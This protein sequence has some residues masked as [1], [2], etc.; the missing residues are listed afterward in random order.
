MILDVFTCNNLTGHYRIRLLM[1]KKKIML[2]NYHADM[3]GGEFAL[4]EH[5]N[6]LL[7]KGMDICV[8]LFHPG[9]LVERL[10]KIGVE[11][12]V[13]NF[14]LKCGPNKAKL[15]GFFLGRHLKKIVTEF[16]PDYILNYTFHEL[17]FFI[18][19]ANCFNIP[20]LYRDQGQAWTNDLNID[21][22]ELKL[23]QWCNSNLQG[24]ICTTQNKF[25]HHI[26]R[27][28]NQNKLKKVYLGINAKKFD[29]FKDKK[30]FFTEFN[31]SSDAITIG[32]FGR[33]I[34]WKGQNFVI[35]AFAK[36]DDPKTHLLIVGGFQLNEIDGND[37]LAYLKKLSSDLGVIERVHF[38]GFR[39]DVPD[40]MN[41]CDIICHASKQEPF[42]LVLAEAMM[43][44]KPVIA[45]DVSGP[46][47]IV[48]EDQTGFLVSVG[49]TALY[50]EKMALLVKDS[51]L[52]EAL[53]F[54]SKQ[55]ARRMFDMDTNFLTLHSEIESLLRM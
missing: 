11:V 29:N 13:L 27:G 19:I 14:K 44:G 2:T 50:S 6:W 21:W 46:R 7:E 43:A 52:R 16:K 32:I 22:R 15:I 26:S 48:V 25:E 12:K 4:L 1:V 41:F 42:G 34:N 40:L 39:D 33:L 18:Q 45:S 8:C 31:I 38:L 35:E 30:T 54:Q 28:V 23:N 20:I 10:E 49:N 24:I 5:A 55:R 9:S 53:G 37:Y 51:Q 3:G 17:P 36:L 47:E